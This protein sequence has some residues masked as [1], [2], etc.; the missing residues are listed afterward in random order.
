MTAA[1]VDSE[2]QGQAE[3]GLS[4]LGRLGLAGRTGFYVILTALTVRIAVLGGRSGRQADAHG[5]LA[6]ISRPLI[7][8][9]AIGA[10]AA[11]F[12]LFGVGRLV[13]AVKDDSVSFGRRALTA[14]QGLF[15]LALAYVP[16]SFL[17]GNHQTGSQQQQQRTT[18]RVLGIPGG[19]IILVAGG[20]I[21]IGV[22]VQQIRGAARQDFRDGLDLGKAPS[23]VRA[24]AGTAG[25]VGIT[26]RA[27]VF[28]P[29][30]IF[31]IVAA[32]QAD[33]SRSYGTDAELLAL[34]GHAW[35]IAVLV[36]VAAGLAVFVVFSAIETGY[37]RV[38]SA[39]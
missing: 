18:A 11:G 23:P 2:E 33:P 36:A 31:L 4:L 32:L 27:L 35:G 29:V 17:A 24:V 26:A 13:G 5:A 14:I 1:A 7:G 39:R 3:R 20:L 34:S 19:K 16:A 10:V 38:I 30:G 21:L 8:K 15:Y 6:L 25:V 22:C 28:L 12:F 37:R 9:V